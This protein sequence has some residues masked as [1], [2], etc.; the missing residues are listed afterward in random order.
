M[1][2]TI[3]VQNPKF[4]SYKFSAKKDYKNNIPAWLHALQQKIGQ[5]LTDR[6]SKNFAK[7]FELATA[8]TTDDLDLTYWKI[9]ADLLNMSIQ[10]QFDAMAEKCVG[11]DTLA[12]LANLTPLIGKNNIDVIAAVQDMRRIYTAIADFPR[13]RT[14][15]EFKNACRKADEIG[16]AHWDRDITKY[17]AEPARIV[18]RLEHDECYTPAYVVGTV[19]EVVQYLAKVQE[20]SRQDLYDKIAK[21]LIVILKS[22]KSAD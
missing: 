1:T 16:D 15:Q 2:K 8:N 14:V 7:N 4:I 6:K 11:C 10:P 18:A 5:N 19:D 13:R 20:V 22:M 21:K 3:L 9:M 17:P 12:K